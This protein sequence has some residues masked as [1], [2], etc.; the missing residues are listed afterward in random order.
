MSIIEDQL[1]K[2]KAAAYDAARMQSMLANAKAQGANEGLAALA[3]EQ[4]YIN[5]NR[6]QQ[7][8]NGANMQQG[9]RGMYEDAI[10]NAP[11][12]SATDRWLEEMRQRKAGLAAQ[13]VQ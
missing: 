11:V 2:Q 13:G 7:F 3:A 9:G 5:A 6:Q 8:V 4:A 1:T 10:D 12:A